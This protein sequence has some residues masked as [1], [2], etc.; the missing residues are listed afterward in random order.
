MGIVYKAVDTSLDRVVAVKSLSAELAKNPD[1]EQ[2]FRAEAKAQA[3]LN[4]TNIATLYAFFVQEGT[5]WMVME[6]IEGETVHDM[7]QRRGPIPAQEAIPLFK[8]ALLGIGYAH[9]MGIVHRDIKPSNIMV[10]RDGIVKVMD[11]GIAKVMG[12]R[13]MT[14]TGTQMGTAYYMSPEQ[15]VNKGVDIRSDIYSLGVTL[16]EMLT[17]NVPF[18]RRYGFRSDAGAHADARRRC[19]RDS[20]RT[21]RRG[22][23]NAV[24]QA[25]AKS[26]NARFQTV[27][28]F[29]AALEHPDDY[30]A[31]FAPAAAAATPINPPSGAMH[32]SATQTIQPRSGPP[33]PPGAPPLPMYST[34]GMPIPT[35]PT[36]LMTAPPPP[37]PP[38]AS[39]SNKKWFL[40]AGAS[41]IVA[42]GAVGYTLR[43]KPKPDPI[44]S[45]NQVT[46]PTAPSAPQGQ[47][48]V[49]IPMP[50]EQPDPNKD[51]EKP[52]AKAQPSQRPHQRRLLSNSSS[53]RR[54][55][56]PRRQTRQPPHLR[57]PRSR[58]LLRRPRRRPLQ[59]R[60][61]RRLR[62][63][64][65][66]RSEPSSFP[67]DSRS[68][69]APSAWPALVAVNSAAQWQRRWQPR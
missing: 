9:R 27:E 30:V 35:P 22:I 29:G 63:S 18:H 2:R 19:P 13:G 69:S 67:P 4:H 1:L 32:P 44:V 31:P 33:L 62:R 60:L 43:P 58:K 51:K 59:H 23:E 38:A 16:Y 20:I 7:I 41:A 37:P 49:P 8:Q 12:N 36:G 54:Q 42:L 66:R 26:P 24:L 48:A 64:R 28:E 45:Q 39:G 15:V 11:F 21:S 3:N 25:M 5:A 46:P 47:I 10:K 6:Y 50:A 34:P 14:R 57:R 52:Q 53:V 40:V 55:R 56:R 68:P 65:Q 61:L 17:A